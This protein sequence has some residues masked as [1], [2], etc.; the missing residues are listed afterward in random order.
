[1]EPCKKKQCLETNE[2]PAVT[3]LGR[4][5]FS[6]VKISKKIQKIKI[7]VTTSCFGRHNATSPVLSDSH[8]LKSFESHTTSFNFSMFS[9]GQHLGKSC[10]CHKLCGL[11]NPMRRGHVALRLVIH[12]KPFQY[13]I[14]A[15]KKTKL[16]RSPLLRLLSGSSIGV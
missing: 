7:D 1:M 6:L 16:N 8:T 3:M 12:G 10:H 11:S 13:Q 14:S 2:E 4:S 15:G 5:V 9:T